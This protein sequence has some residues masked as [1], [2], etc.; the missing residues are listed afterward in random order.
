M[1]SATAAAANITTTRRAASRL[2]LTNNSTRRTA[3][4]MP[5]IINNATGQTL[6]RSSAASSIGE[7]INPTNTLYVFK[8]RDV[9]QITLNNPRNL[10]RLT[11]KI[12]KELHKELIKGIVNPINKMVALRATGSTHMIGGTDLPSIY[13]IFYGEYLNEEQAKSPS[14]DLALQHAVVYLKDLYSLATT[15]IH[16][17]RVT[18]LWNGHSLIPLP[19]ALLGPGASFHVPQLQYGMVP[20]LGSTWLLGQLDA[21]YPGVAMYMA[22]FSASKSTV[23][24][25]AQLSAL[26]IGQGEA[27]EGTFDQMLL[28]YASQ[29]ASLKTLDDM[30]KFVCTPTLS[31]QLA[32]IDPA[33]TGVKSGFGFMT[34]NI[35]SLP[36]EDIKEYFG[37]LTDPNDQSMDH[38]TLNDLIQKLKNEANSFSNSSSKREW[39][40]HMVDTLN[41]GSLEVAGGVFAM[42]KNVS[43]RSFTECC[44][45]EYRLTHRLLRDRNSDTHRALRFLNNFST[46]NSKIGDYEAYVDPKIW[47]TGDQIN[48][49]FELKM[50]KPLTWTEDQGIDLSLGGPMEMESMRKYV[51]KLQNFDPKAKNE[52]YMEG[53]K[54]EIVDKQ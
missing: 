17:K 22:L 10:N 39:C 8:K 9:K 51:E 27:N 42:L 20:D 29:T 14:I 45:M 15:L 32:K 5:H 47:K 12:T 53:F 44:T 1:R 31:N 40:Q 28:D 11:P 52:S 48:H 19:S 35:L 41:S 43:G 6:H 3:Y 23:I 34:N 4:T 25:G 21:K 13:D 49:D 24:K 33:G 18:P 30:L 54:F 38:M 2:I 37:P 36:L 7:P 26:G 46:K 16:S 50:N